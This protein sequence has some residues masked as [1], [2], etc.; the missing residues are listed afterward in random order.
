MAMYIIGDRCIACAAC[1]DECPVDAIQEE[2]P[3]F[4]VIEDEKCIDC[5]AC[6]YVCPT[7]AILYDVDTAVKTVEADIVSATAKIE[8]AKVVAEEAKEK[9]IHC[10]LIPEREEREEEAKK[11]A[12]ALVEAEEELAALNAT[13]EKVEKDA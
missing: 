1:W 9:V 8:D 13:L 5:G 10:S 11:A 6:S 7:D 2:V 3:H 12:E 4:F